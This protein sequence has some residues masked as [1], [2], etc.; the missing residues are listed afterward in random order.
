MN[1]SLSIDM[2]AK[3]TPVWTELMP[4]ISTPD[5]VLSNGSDDLDMPIIYDNKAAA[6][7]SVLEDMNELDDYDGYAALVKFDGVI[8]HIL[9]EETLEIIDTVKDW[10][11]G[12]F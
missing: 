1:K 3:N 11:L 8:M 4:T 12:R 2:P 5:V 7:A 6:E 10:T 9:D